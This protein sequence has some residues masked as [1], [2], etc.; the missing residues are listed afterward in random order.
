MT[1]SPSGKSWLFPVAGIAIVAVIGLLVFRATQSSEATEEPTPATGSA[2][3]AGSPASGA[4]A[5]PGTLTIKHGQGETVVPKHPK[6]VVVFDPVALDMLDALGVE[7]LGVPDNLLPPHLKAYEGEK[8]L[9]LGTRFE[10]NYEAVSKA[11]PDL[12]ISGSRSSPK[13]PDLAKIATT[14]DL[15]ADDTRFIETVISNT[16]L[17]ASIF[18]KQE[19]AKELTDKLRADIAALKEKTKDRGTGLI[20]L[21]TGG[22]ISAYG[23]G[24]RFGAI[25]TDF[26][27][28]VAKEGLNPSR[29]G[30]SIG[31]EF[32]QKTNPDWLFVVDRDVAVGNE[33]GAE[34]LLDNE[35]VRQTTAWK[36]KQVVY[37]D[38]T[39][40]Y[41]AAGGIQAISKLLSQ[42]REAYDKVIAAAEPAAAEASP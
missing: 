15:P 5:A 40:A 22:K 16:E 39:S 28:P 1:S 31:S 11:K 35:L 24:S 33:A 29:H 14:I 20:I 36:K 10:P 13:Y 2:E 23:P 8:Y 34:K 32:I 21:T 6:R 4:P 38:A 30:E 41:L 26:G 37:L 25:H 9:K 19:K 7:V 27:V 12:V 18:D 17:L 42:I 3:A